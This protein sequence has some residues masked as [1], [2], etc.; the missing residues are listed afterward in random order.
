M[1]VA[2]LAVGIGLW[3]FTGTL[4]AAEAR[5]E[6]LCACDE[7]TGC[8]WVDSAPICAEGTFCRVSPLS[9][10]CTGE[11]AGSVAEGS[12]RENP[13]R[14]TILWAERDQLRSRPL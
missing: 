10:A 12:C 2:W 6:I 14:G 9:A 8:A 13:L 7:E 4:Q 5:C 1:K 3:W 11:Q